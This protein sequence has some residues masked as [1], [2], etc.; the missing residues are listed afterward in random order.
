MVKYF[1]VASIIGPNKEFEIMN[2]EKEFDDDWC[3]ITS[4]E[5]IAEIEEDLRI[6]LI[7][8]EIIPEDEAYMFNINIINWKKFDSWWLKKFQRQDLFFC[9]FLFNF[10]ETRCFFII[11][12]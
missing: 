6:E 4:I 9:R 2:F 12:N 11:R 10:L 5:D 7:E 8:N 1:I 3:P